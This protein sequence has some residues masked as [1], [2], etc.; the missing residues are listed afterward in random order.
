MADGAVIVD[1]GSGLIGT[2]AL[3][4]FGQPLEL[5]TF[6]ASATL[7][8]VPALKVIDGLPWPLTSVPFVTV[9]EYVAPAV[10]LTL[11]LMFVALAQTDAGA[12]TVAFGAR[13]MKVKL[14]ALVAVPPAVVTEIGPVVIVAGTVAVIWVALFSTND[15]AGVPLK[16]TADAPM[17]FVPLIVTVVPA[18]PFA[19]E[20]LVIA[21]ADAVKHLPVAPAKKMF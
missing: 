20:K 13:Q 6:T 14:L 21:G 10:A 17:R 11:A 16:E 1:D 19:G 9:H 12:V 5:V 4:L 18:P 3:P 15:A 2:L 8:D 7:P